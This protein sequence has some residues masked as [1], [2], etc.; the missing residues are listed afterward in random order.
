M[1]VLSMFR[2][3]G[4]PELRRGDV[5]YLNA[6]NAA[7]VTLG[8]LHNGAAQ[9][10]DGTIAEVRISDVALGA[11]QFLIASVPE[12]GTLA[13]LVVAPLLLGARL[14]ARAGVTAGVAHR[15]SPV[16]R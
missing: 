6:V 16:S 9:R 5:P 8:A 3:K 13:L 7:Q 14:R 15:R 4:G 11:D 12:P 2:R 10:L 1:S